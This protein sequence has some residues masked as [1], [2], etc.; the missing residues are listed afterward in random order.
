MCT[1]TYAQTC[2]WHKHSCVY[3]WV[4]W[5]KQLRSR[6]VVGVT[7]RTGGVFCIVLSKEPRASWRP[8]WEA[9]R[10]PLCWEYS[11]IQKWLPGAR[12]H[13]QKR[14]QEVAQSIWEAAGPSARRAGW[15]HGKLEAGRAK[16]S[17]RQLL[18]ETGLEIET[19][20]EWSH[21]LYRT[22]LGTDTP[23][24]KKKSTPYFPVFS[25]HLQTLPVHQIRPKGNLKFQESFG[26]LVVTIMLLY[27]P[28]E[29]P[30]SSWP[31]NPKYKPQ[32]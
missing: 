15:P 11:R 19:I 4:C 7:A 12:I 23:Q 5:L 1:Y 9:P 20:E 28:R 3:I 21:V 30:F 27:W 24:M 32:G 26:S 6:Q 14:R 25:E 16:H 8:E 22:H 10:P 29:V 18:Q 31:T 13:P 2:G 17:E